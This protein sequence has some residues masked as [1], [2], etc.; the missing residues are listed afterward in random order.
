MNPKR[1]PEPSASYDSEFTLVGA[2]EIVRRSMLRHHM[3][4]SANVVRLARLRLAWL[5]R[6]HAKRNSPPRGAE[7]ADGG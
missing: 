4:Q 6:E 2:L 7:A 1:E 5:E 3:K